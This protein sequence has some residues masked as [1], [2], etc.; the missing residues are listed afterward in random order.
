MYFWNILEVKMQDVL[1]ELNRKEC[2]TIFVIHLIH[3][4]S[5]VHSYSLDADRL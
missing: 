3:L 5:S 2:P 4:L 1:L